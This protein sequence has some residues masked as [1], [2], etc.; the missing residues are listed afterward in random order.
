MTLRIIAD[1]DEYGN[2][3]YYSYQRFW[4]VNEA[5]GPFSIVL[6][7]KPRLNA[8]WDK[9]S[10]TCNKWCIKTVITAIWRTLSS[11]LN[12]LQ[13]V[14]GLMTSPTLDSF[15]VVQLNRILPSRTVGHCW[16]L[17]YSTFQHG[18]SLSTLYRKM[19][20]YDSPVLLV[21]TDDAHQVSLLKCPSINNRQGIIIKIVIIVVVMIIYAF[22][23]SISKE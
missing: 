2:G 22:I 3:C 10:C 8:A 13:A 6:T 21:V 7:N 5:Y 1:S 20:V 19:E 16:E 11:K 15:Y 18:F 12:D 9:R 23:G 4:H 17:V 14:W